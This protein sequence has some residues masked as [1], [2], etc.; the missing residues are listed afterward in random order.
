LCSAPV[1]CPN[2]VCD[3]GETNATCP[4]DC[5]VAP[6]PSCPNATNACNVASSAPGCSNKAC[7]ATVCAADPFCC[8]TAWDDVC[9]NQAATLCSAPVL[10]PNGVCDAG[11][12][13]A[14]CPAD[15]PV[16]P[17][18]S[19]PNATNACTA[20]SGAPG[21]SDKA[22]CAK[23]CAL[24][25]FCCA[26]SW[27]SACVGAVGAQC[28]GQANVP[29]CPGTGSCTTA[30]TTKGCS[31]TACCNLVCTAD[32]FCCQTQWDSICA[33]QAVQNCGL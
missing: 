4:A 29:G 24:D 27:D 9:V 17:P 19:C 6:P 12:T 18:P 11:E 20:T 28:G 10:C 26:T 31:N 30:K 8:A 1:L 15:C 13:N 32:S 16:T 7:C 3:A 23:V 22:C 5:P 2:G 33:Q 21:C 14:T 25:P